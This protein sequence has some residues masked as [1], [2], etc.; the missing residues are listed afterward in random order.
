MSITGETVRNAN[1]Q[2]CLRAP[3]SETQ[4]RVPGTLRRKRS[5]ILPH[6]LRSESRSGVAL[7]ELPYSM[8]VKGTPPMLE[9]FVLCPPQSGKMSQKFQHPDSISQVPWHPEVPQKSFVRSVFHSDGNAV[10]VLSST[11]VTV[12]CDLW[13]I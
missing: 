2:A 8:N 7:G 5:P 13:N 9:H 6:T 3:E 4:G 1:P 12:T 11:E 10:P